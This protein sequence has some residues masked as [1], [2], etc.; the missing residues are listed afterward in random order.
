LKGA[1]DF[2]K[3][4]VSITAISQSNIFVIRPNDWSILA[5]KYSS[6]VQDPNNYRSGYTNFALLYQNAHPTSSYLE[7]STYALLKI[8][9]GGITLLRVP[10]GSSD[11]EP[12]TLDDNDVVTVVPCNQN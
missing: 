7:Q 4:N 10:Y 8:F 3:N 6:Y 5:Q 2:Y 9:G 12:V 11:F 1:T